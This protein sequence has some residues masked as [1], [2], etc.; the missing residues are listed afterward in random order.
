MVELDHMNT[1]VFF[2]ILLGGS[3]AKSRS[4]GK[5]ASARKSNT[6]PNTTKEQRKSKKQIS[7]A[8]IETIRQIVDM[9]RPYELSK[10]QRLRTYQT[11]M[12]DDAVSNAFS[13]NSIL[14]EK[15]FSNYEVTY[16]YGDKA[17]SEAADFLKWNLHNL[18]G[19][20][21]VRGIARSAAEFKRDGLAPFEKSYKK[22]KGVW[23]DYWTINKL[24]Y[25]HPLSLEPSNPFTIE[26]GGRY[27]TEMRQSLKAFR[28]TSDML[29]TTPESRAKGYVS[30]PRNKLAFMTYSATESQPFGTSAF[31]ACYTAWREKV[32]IQDY[33]LVGVTK[34]FSGTPV[35]YLP[36]AILSAANEDPSSAAGVMVSGLQA[37]MANMHTGDQSY[38]ILP[39]DTQSES[40]NGARDYEIKFLGVEGGGKSFDVEALVEQRKKAIYNSFGAANLITGDS[41][42]G[43]YNL[44]SGQNTIH[45]HYVE[46]DIAIIEEVWNTDIIPQLFR[47]NEWDLSYDQVPKLVAGDIEPVSLEE[48][49][50]YFN[51]VMRSLPAVP[52]VVNHL[53]AKQKIP[54]R[55]PEGTTPEEIR[56]MLFDFQ[57]ES[58]VGTGEGSSGQG[59]SQSSGSQSDTNS[60]N[61]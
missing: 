34:D 50:K 58:K 9:L 52:D 45:S 5:S 13:A 25:V 38:T 44:I 15:A 59:S 18:G 56:A 21:T 3:V 53:L 49:G 54:Y 1:Y 8:S 22:G 35:L 57:E 4:K 30:I 6:T 39:S 27:V 20:Q 19:F 40:G 42:G 17:S 51:R 16:K 55:V 10:T 41:S 61:K 60:E 36:E 2:S 14:I 43:S 7:T 28:N 29:A 23:S 33:T 26:G 46:R 32:L 11:M 47:L 12:L 24:N 48:D 31:D 37:N